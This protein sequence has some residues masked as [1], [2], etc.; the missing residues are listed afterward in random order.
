MR[1]IVPCA[2][3]L[4]SAFALAGCVAETDGAWR[5]PAWE[6]TPIVETEPSETANPVTVDGLA[7]HRIRNDDLGLQARFTYLPGRDPVV[8]EYNATVENAVWELIDTRS[9]ATAIDYRPQAHDVGAGFADRGCVD[10]AA[11]RPAADLLGDPT[12]GPV[13]GDGALVVCEIVLARGPFFGQ[14][15]RAI[16]GGPAEIVADTQLTHLVDTDSGELF[17]ANALWNDQAAAV[18]GVGIIDRMRRDAGALTLAAPTIDPAAV[19]TV[20]ASL[21]TT[22]PT[23]DGL[24][25]T[26]AGGFTAEA[27]V[28]LGAPAHA[29]PIS[30]VIPAETAQPLLTDLGARVVAAA[31]EPYRGPARGAAG[32]DRIDCTLLPCVALTYDDGPGEHTAG[33]L[34]TLADHHAA[35]TFFVQGQ[36]IASRADVVRRAVEEGH[37][38]E[39]HSWNHPHLPALTPPEIVRQLKDTNAAIL[40]ATGVPARA[41]RPPYGE[42]SPA[43]LAAAGMPAILWDVDVRDWAGL[44]DAEVTR[45]AVTGPEPGS[46]VLQH[47]VQESTARTADAVYAGLGDRGFSLVTLGQLFTD[48]LPSSGAW[49]SAR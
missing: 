23:P 41:F 49:R 8:D 38:V 24:R 45:Q 37:A 33:M 29:G 27:L 20:H 48:G 42:H 43:V 34:D 46:I 2:S 10:G 13:D 18:I 39:N 5:P 47:D 17:D 1:R 44:S 9:E 35:A 31:E 40:D 7:G 32:L 3:L 25:I 12:I 26:L 6:P 36:Y 15:I 28:E 14:R 11:G 21:S 16:A 30:I 22:T 19:E 4:A